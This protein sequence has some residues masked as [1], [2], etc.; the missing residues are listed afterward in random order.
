MTSSA[1][2]EHRPK[3]YKVGH[4]WCI[5]CSCSDESPLV[6]L[7]SS[8]ISY[9]RGHAVAVGLREGVIEDY[10]YLLESPKVPV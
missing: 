1:A 6:S 3:V 7:R 5:T 8:A 4:H 9:W 10:L 2:A